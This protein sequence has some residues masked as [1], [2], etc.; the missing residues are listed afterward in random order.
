ML[1]PL[2]CWGQAGDEKTEPS[3]FPV[4]HLVPSFNIISCNFFNRFILHG[5]IVFYSTEKESKTKG[6]ATDRKRMENNQRRCF[7]FSDELVGFSEVARSVLLQLLS[8]HGF[9]L[10]GIRAMERVGTR[11]SMH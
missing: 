2:S 11:S 4:V 9:G 1:C 6:A 7:S 8:L 10:L 5:G 3:A